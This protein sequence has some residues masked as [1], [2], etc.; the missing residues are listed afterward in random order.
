[1]TESEQLD[2]SMKDVGPLLKELGTDLLAEEKE[3]IK[4]LL[5]DHYWKDI[6]RG[7]AFGFA[8]WY[9]G[10]L[11]ERQLDDTEA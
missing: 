2:H 6:Q 9:R 8:E 11:L 3:A 7:V 5:F 1:M 10:Q 4:D